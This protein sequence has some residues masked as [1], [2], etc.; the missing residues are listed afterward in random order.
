MLASY[1]YIAWRTINFPMFFSL[2]KG[3]NILWRGTVQVSRPEK[4]WSN[5]FCAG[6]AETVGLHNERIRESCK[7][8]QELVV[9]C[10]CSD[11]TNID[12]S[13]WH[14]KLPF[15]MEIDNLFSVS[16]LLFYVSLF[17]GLICNW[18]L[19]LRTDNI[20]DVLVFSHDLTRKGSNV[21]I[22]QNDACYKYS[23]LG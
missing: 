20:M 13:S 7:T 6:R 15:V 8:G 21:S 16:F 2:R 5:G 9:A 1:H 18:S 12:T 10:S 14:G 3:Q 19:S 11:G 23:V 4:P 17:F 22:Y